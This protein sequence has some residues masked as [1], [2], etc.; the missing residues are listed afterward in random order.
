MKCH[1]CNNEIDDKAEECPICGVVFDRKAE[2][3][4][5]IFHSKKADS[6]FEKIYYTIS[7]LIYMGFGGAI[8]SSFW[9]PS[10]M[11]VIPLWG[12]LIIGITLFLQGIIKIILAFKNNEVVDK[13]DTICSAG[14]SIGFLV[15][16]FGFLIFFDYTIISTSEMSVALPALLFTLIFW[17]FGIY[18][19]ISII[20][21]L[22]AKL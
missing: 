1:Y 15:L 21:Q 4:E 12:F 22:K 19:V 20:K 13:I 17:G 10:F 18:M 3:E 7:G 14:Y 2:K 16:W 11:S 6:V 8:I 9:N 5:Y